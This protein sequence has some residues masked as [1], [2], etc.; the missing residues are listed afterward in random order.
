MSNEAKRTR[1]SLWG[2]AAI[3]LASAGCG[4]SP[5]ATPADAARND[6]GAVDVP[7]AAD[8]VVVDAAVAAD[9]VDSATNDA[10]ATDAADASDASSD[11][12]ADGA[13]DVPDAGCVGVDAGPLDPAF[14]AI[15]RALVEANSCRQCHGTDLSGNFTGVMF[16]GHTMPAYPPNLTPDRATGIGCWTNDQLMSAILD[17]TDNVG[18]PLCPPMPH[19]S[20]HGLDQ[21][22][23]LAIVSFL[24]SLPPSSNQVP[25]TPVCAAW[26]RLGGGCDTTADCATGSV[27]LYQFCVV[28]DAGTPDA[29]IDAGGDASTGVD[30]ATD[31]RRSDASSR[32]AGATDATTTDVGTIDATIVDVVAPTDAASVPSDAGDGGIDESVTADAGVDESITGDAGP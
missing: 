9:A 17:G 18:M 2:V 29:S 4:T 5:D 21:A 32:D 6:L 22:D 11:A 7:A 23:A 12:A 25:D 24:R 10:A 30:A 26:G 8:V 31:A 20:N 1:T 19:F 14:V 16:V 13:G 3:A 28:P 15:G 27:C